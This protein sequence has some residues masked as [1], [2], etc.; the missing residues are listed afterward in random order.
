MVEGEEVRKKV[1]KNEYL[2]IYPYTKKEEN[3]LPKRLGRKWEERVVTQIS[4]VLPYPPSANTIWRH[5]KGKVLLSE[6]GRLYRRKVAMSVLSQIGRSEAI[7]DPVA[8]SI[9]VMPPDRRRRDLDNVLKATLDALTH[10]KVWGDDSQVKRIEMEMQKPVKG[11]S[12]SLCI[13]TQCTS[14][15]K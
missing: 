5:V 13:I 4:L 1:L 15:S 9:L 10:A 6:K 3:F 8:I 2:Y 14:V 11:G 7:C 12:L